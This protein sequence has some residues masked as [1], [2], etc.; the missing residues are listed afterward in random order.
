MHRVGIYRQCSFS[1][2]L[3]RSVWQGGRLTFWSLLGNGI[4]G[5]VPE[6]RHT[7]NVNLNVI[8]IV[9][10]LAS[11]LLG[12]CRAVLKLYHFRRLQNRQSKLLQPLWHR[13]CTEEDHAQK[14][15]LKAQ[16]ASSAQGRFG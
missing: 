5:I 14:T 6:G 10:V 2:V 9:I 15:L 13:I 8:V 12:R 3:Q 11:V 16:Q 4:A 7:A 1:S